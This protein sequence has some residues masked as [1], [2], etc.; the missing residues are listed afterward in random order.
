M[1]KGIC[2]DMSRHVEQRGLTGHYR[3]RPA[4]GLHSR[5]KWSAVPLLVAKQHAAIVPLQQ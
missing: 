2:A 1:L 5:C 3:N 4:C